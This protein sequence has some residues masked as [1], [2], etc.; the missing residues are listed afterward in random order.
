MSMRQW[1]SHVLPECKRLHHMADEIT[2]AML[3]ALA[4]ATEAEIGS[5]LDE[6][7]SCTLYSSAREVSAFDTAAAAAA[8][9]ALCRT[10]SSSDAS[11]VHVRSTGPSDD[12]K[13]PTL[14]SAYQKIES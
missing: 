9:S 12:A 5:V 10:A 1:N 6:A 2:F 14:H 11:R 3:A 13:V 4:T 7:A 8:S